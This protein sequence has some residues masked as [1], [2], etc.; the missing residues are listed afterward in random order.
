MH[1]DAGL[2]VR[3][4]VGVSA[5]VVAALEHEDPETQVGCAALGDGQPEA[6]S[7]ITRAVRLVGGRRGGGG[8]EEDG[9]DTD[10]L[11]IGASTVY[12]PGSRP[13]DRRAAPRMPRADRSARTTFAASA[14]PPR[15]G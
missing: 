10:L 5:E 14:L 6:G 11:T 1:L 3:L 7:T 12:V 8:A 4:A 13:H 9:E 15:S 2:G